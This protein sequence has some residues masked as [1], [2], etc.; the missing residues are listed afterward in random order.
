M[1]AIAKFVERILE[2]ILPLVI[3]ATALLILGSPLT[4]LALKADALGA[5]GLSR[6]FLFSMLIFYCVGTMLAFADLT[7]RLRS[8]GDIFSAIGSTR[9]FGWIVY[10]AKTSTAFG[11]TFLIRA[12]LMFIGFMPGVA[13]FVG[14]FVWLY[15]IYSWLRYGYWPDITALDWLYRNNIQAPNLEWKGIDQVLMWFLEFPIGWKLMV[16]GV[17]L[18]TLRLY[19]FFR[20]YSSRDR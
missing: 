5:E 9:L 10:A 7:L 3:W 2:A 15:Q 6:F 12:L 20:N 8:Q 17:V 13:I 16:I 18:K 1:S 14:F 4:I 11:Q 19:F